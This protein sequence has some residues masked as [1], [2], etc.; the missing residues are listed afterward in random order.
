[1]WDLHSLLG[2]TSRCGELADSGAVLPPDAMAE[3]VAGGLRIRR[4]I[5]D[6]ATGELLDLTPRSWP[7]PRTAA[8]ELDAPV[9]LS[10]II[11]NTQWDAIHDGSADPALLAAVDQAP[12]AVRDLLTHPR[13]A[14]RLDDTPAA[15]PPPARLAEFIA[16][17][18]RHPVNPG[19]GPTAAAAADIDHTI[20]VRDGGTTIAD[21]LASLVRR[22]HNLK[23]HGGWSVTRIDRGWQWTSPRGHTY[24]TQPYDYRL[25]P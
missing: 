8:T 17:R 16:V 15:L 22:W 23:T 18:D 2:L 6:D 3:L 9:V 20:S 11:T 14:D 12:Q 21:N 4:M 24:Q 10:V 13:T 25:G 5:I 1:L 7:L 19:A